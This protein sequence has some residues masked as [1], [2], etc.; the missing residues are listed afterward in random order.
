MK[1][2][3]FT[4]R[5]LHSDRQSHIEHGSLH[6][7]VHTSIAF[8]HESAESIA[9][10]FQGKQPGFTYGRQ[11]NPTT[12]ALEDKITLMEDGLASVCFSTGM[13]AIA[14]CMLALLRKGDHLISSSFLFGNTNSFFTTLENFGIEVS[15]V[16]ATDAASVSAAVKANTRMV[17]TETIA[18]PCTQVSDL[19]EIGELCAEKNLLYVV[20]NTMTSPCVF[21]PKSVKASLVIN[22]LSKIICGH[23]NALGGSITETGLFDWRGY[24]NIAENY[25]SGKPEKWGLQQIRKK[26]LRDTGGTLAPQAAHIIAV[27]AETLALRASK[28]GENAL[29]LARM[30]RDHPKIKKVFY[31]GLEQHPEHQRAQELFNTFGALMSIELIDSMDCFDFLDRLQM[32]IISSNLG[33]NRTLAI[34]VAHTIFHEMGAERRR[35]MGIGDNMIRLSIGIEDYGDLHDDFI[36]ALQ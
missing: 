11:I 10:V 30:F 3:G 25:K 4:T 29:K 6:K 15:F 20:D 36:Q 13:A 26:G 7:P 35:T 5:I 27:G 9:E 8:A 14:A 31:P 12:N 21:R 2:R 34:P 16:D 1:T 18:N 24:P 19:K 17:F 23:G 28:A 22:S 33:D 32:V